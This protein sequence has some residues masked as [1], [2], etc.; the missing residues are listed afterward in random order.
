LSELS[1]GTSDSG[2]QPPHAQTTFLRSVAHHRLGNISLAEDIFAGLLQGMLN[3][4]IQQWLAAELHHNHRY[5]EHLKSREFPHPNWAE[6]ERRF[7]FLSAIAKS[8]MPYEEIPDQKT[9]LVLKALGQSLVERAEARV[10]TLEPLHRRL[11]FYIMEMGPVDRDVILE[12]FWPDL[13]PGRQTASLYTTV[14]G[15][16]AALGDDILDTQ[17][18]LYQLNPDL[19][20]SYDVTEFERLVSLA[21]SMPIGDPRR[22]FALRESTQLYT[23]EFLP[24]FVH[25]WVLQRRREL[26]MLQVDTLRQFSEAAFA[27]GRLEE[28]RRALEAALEIEPL[29]DDLHHKYLRILGALGM[30]SELVSHYQHY[31]RLLRD[32]LGLDPPLEIRQLYE[33]LIK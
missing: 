25:E 12:D 3:K 11:L 10:D 8:W 1:E 29:H 32:E 17:G 20:I 30:R 33:N 15:L 14:H 27:K 2:E 26:E 28:A 23:G 24:E 19:S 13:P 7:D 31:A 9:Y 21:E 18:S 22:Y 5:Y 16:R 4:Q 6:L